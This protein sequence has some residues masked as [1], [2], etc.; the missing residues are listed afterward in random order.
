[1]KI[2]FLDIDGVLNPLS[3]GAFLDRSLDPECLKQLEH[4]VDSTG[5]KLIITSLR[6]L[7]YQGVPGFNDDW[8]H[9]SKLAGAVLD[10]TPKLERQVGFLWIAAPRWQEIL[11]WLNRTPLVESWAVV[12]DDREG[13]RGLDPTRCVYTDP[14]MGLSLTE[15][16]KLIKL[17]S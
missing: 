3:E 8:F 11:A 12:D 15:A 10:F 17:L 14:T 6:R 4:V 16:E 2:L 5:C 1:M 9:G 7:R 13:L